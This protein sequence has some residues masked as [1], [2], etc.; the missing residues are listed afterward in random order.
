MFR[1]DFWCGI[2]TEIENYLFLRYLDKDFNLFSVWI[3][4]MN[5]LRWIVPCD[6]LSAAMK[7][8]GAVSAPLS[9]QMAISKIL[10]Y[11]IWIR[12]LWLFLL[13]FI[14]FAQKIKNLGLKIQVSELSSH[15]VAC[16]C[17][18]KCPLTWPLVDWSLTCVCVCSL[19][20]TNRQND[21]QIV[22][23]RP[24][25]PLRQGRENIIFLSNDVM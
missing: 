14:E 12:S 24:F 5:G 6:E 4:A 13:N 8:A 19:V 23:I 3:L 21:R 18:R 7:C 22:Y 15:L 17:R 16:V 2:C 10:F 25:P 9:K 1:L 11:Y 20:R